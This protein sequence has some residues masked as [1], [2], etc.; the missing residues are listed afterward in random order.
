MRHGEECDQPA[1]EHEP[2]GPPCVR[3]VAGQHE[4]HEPRG[5]LTQAAHRHIEEPE[6]E[7]HQ[8]EETEEDAF[9]VAEHGIRPHGVVAHGAEEQEPLDRLE[10]LRR[11][12]RPEE[13][14]H[15]L[16][17]SQ[18]HVRECECEEQVDE[19]PRLRERVAQLAVVKLPDEHAEDHEAEEHV[20]ALRQRRLR[21]ATRGAGAALHARGDEQH[22]EQQVGRVDMEAPDAVKERDVRRD[23]ARPRPDRV[24]ELLDR[25]RGDQQHHRPVLRALREEERQQE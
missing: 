9:L 14:P 7:R 3:E 10:R 8:E 2:R 5:R 4:R 1:A 19:G 20:E 23:R 11:D 15:R 16:A 22:H 18:E 13:R 6:C 21:P 12:K 25:K 17:R 24:A